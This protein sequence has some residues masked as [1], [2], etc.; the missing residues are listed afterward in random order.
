M[1]TLNLSRPRERRGNSLE[2]PAI[3]LSNPTPALLEA[4][5]VG[6]TTTGITVTERK[7]M[8]LSAVYSCVRIIAE[9]LASLPFVAYERLDRGKRRATTHPVYRLLHDRPNPE[10]PP[11]QFI[12]TMTGHVALTGNA[13]AE[14]EWNNRAQPVALWP[15]TPDRVRVERASGEKRYVVSVPTGAPVSL[16]RDRI[17]HIAGFGYDGLVGYSPIGLMRQTVSV[18]L[19]AEEYAARFYGNGSRPGG[20]LKYPGKMSQQA[21]ENLKASWERIQGGLSNAHRVAILEEGL[22]WQKIQIDPDDAQ[23]IETRKFQVTDIAR[24]FRVPPHMIAD[25]DKATFS[26]IEQQSLEFVIHT[27]RPWAVRWEQTVTHDLF[28]DY[29]AGNYFAEF[30]V[31]GLLRGDLASRYSAYAVGRNNGW[32]SA[33]DIRELENMNPLPGDQGEIYLVPANM[34]PADQVARGDE[35][36]ETTQDEA[37]EDDAEA[38]DAAPEVERAR[39]LMR[40]REALTPVFA[41]AAERVARRD[42]VARDRAAKRGIPLVDVLDGDH[43]AGVAR[44]FL[45]AMRA[46]VA[47]AAPTLGEPARVALAERMAR[48][49]A[50]RHA[51]A[52]RDGGAAP[53]ALPAV[54]ADLDEYFPV[55]AAVHRAA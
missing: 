53:D 9:S 54:L 20:V 45:P 50:E 1:I 40:W 7:A 19:A 18:A 48:A 43:E 33:N 5:G 37:E 47:L 42:D 26:N 24:I 23:F 15:L 32:L 13:Y 31:E 8:T 55:A 10:M 4:L 51:R 3:P 41:D 38:D 52:V 29:S 16:S 39:D 44:V 35:A 36:A 22:E 14:I 46:L 49:H 11:M 6:P 25:L 27:L 2:N 21:K 12:E 17:L 28:S 30:V 34:V